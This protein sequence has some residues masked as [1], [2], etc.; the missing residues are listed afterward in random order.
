MQAAFSFQV[1][2]NT[3]LGPATSTPAPPLPVH[4]EQKWKK[5]N[6]TRAASAASAS[7]NGKPSGV[8]LESPPPYHC[9]IGAGGGSG[10]ITPISSCNDICGKADPCCS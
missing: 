10:G 4:S 5:S 7:C 9:A 3:C 6:V 2:I 1:N 8:P